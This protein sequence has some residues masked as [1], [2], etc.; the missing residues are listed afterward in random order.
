MFSRITKNTKVLRFSICMKVVDATFYDLVL[1]MNRGLSSNVS[2]NDF[3]NERC[4]I[5]AFLG[6]DL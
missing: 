2:S 5:D 3:P 6:L 4:G 1:L